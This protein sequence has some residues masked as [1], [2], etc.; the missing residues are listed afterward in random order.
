[1]DRTRRSCRII[2]ITCLTGFILAS[3][4]LCA[5]TDSSWVVPDRSI[6]FSDSTMRPVYPQKDLTDVYYSITKKKKDTVVTRIIK[7]V[8]YHFS[9]VPA[10]GY[11]LSTGLAGILAS[12]VAFLAKDPE[13]TNVSNIAIQA[14]YSQYQQLTIPI[15]VNWWTRDN[16]YNIIADW[17]YYKYPQ[18]TYGL[19]GHSSLNNDDELDY[20]QFRIHQSV[21][22]KI[23]KNIYAGIGYFLDYHWNVKES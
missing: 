17:R 19:G 8:K 11:T 16:E 2:I 23:D 1:M 6:I 21:L 5:Q 4:E 10:V 7:P 13:R 14:V 18:D 3:T 20:S 15:L 22:K 12:N 9:F